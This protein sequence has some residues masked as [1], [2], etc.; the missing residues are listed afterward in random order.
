[1][2]VLSVLAVSGIVITRGIHT[3]EFNFNTDET[4]HA[5]TGLYFAD[6]LRDL[7]LGHPLEYTFR[8]YAQYPALGVLHWP[9]IFHMFEGLAFFLFGS[10]VVVARA[11]ILMFALLGIYFQ[12]RLVEYVENKLAA[13][14]ASLLFAFLP[15]SLLFEKV[16]MLEIPALS[17]SIGAIY[18]WIRYLKEERKADIYRFAFFACAALLTKQTVAFLIPVCVL[19]AVLTKRVQIF[20]QKTTWYVAA[21]CGAVLSPY[22][23]AM[24]HFHGA[25]LAK[26]VEA[27]HPVTLLHRATFYWAALPGQMT[28]VVLALSMLGIVTYCARKEWEKLAFA[29]AWILGCYVT[30]TPI[31]HQEPRFIIYWLPAWAWLGAVPFTVSLGQSVART[32]QTAA[33]IVLL[34]A[35]ALWALSY[36]RPYVGGYGSAARGLVSMAKSGYVL[37]D[38]PLPGN[39]IFFVRASDPSRRIGVLRK[40][41]YVTM[42]SKDEGSEE[43]VHGF[44]GIRNVLAADGV[45]YI[46]VAENAPTLFPVQHTLRDLLHS[47]HQFRLRAVFPV[48]GC[49]P[50]RPDTFLAIY[51]NLQ[52]SGAAAPYLHL[53]MLTTR[54][55]LDVPFGTL[56][57][58]PYSFNLSGQ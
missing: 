49:D 40:A 3:G 34:S 56:G 4:I 45:R 58:P 30:L 39:F 32:I 7:P 55:D 47:D 35:Q 52:A 14:I 57:P 25:A 20:L 26:S 19:A 23:L 10:T 15:L 16:V 22:Y 12:F 2:L 41:L 28:W 46:V 21:V 18:F 37:F 48:R 24:S 44:E 9:P 42:I 53:K 54:H 1:M 31:G 33:A 27:S 51:E 6:F 11:T 36:Q 8:Y 5:S 38:G 43:L 29:M 50:M 17:L 13:V